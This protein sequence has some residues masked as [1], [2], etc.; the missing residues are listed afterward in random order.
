MPGQRRGTIRFMLSADGRRGPVRLAGDFTHWHPVSMRKRGD[1]YSVT[2]PATRGSHEYRFLVDGTWI[3][4]PDNVNTSVT[5][6]GVNSVA[7][8]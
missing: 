1:T 3:A 4:D 8:L 5:P 2:V 6:L 7:M